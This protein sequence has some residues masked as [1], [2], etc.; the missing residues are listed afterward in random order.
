MMLGRLAFFTAS[1]FC[2]AQALRENKNNIANKA[3][4]KTKLCGFLFMN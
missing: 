1:F 3:M 2:C 4:L